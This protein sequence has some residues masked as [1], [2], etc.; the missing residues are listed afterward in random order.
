MHEPKASA[1]RNRDRYC[2]IRVRQIKT[3]GVHKE[4][5]AYHMTFSQSQVAGLA[6][7]SHSNLS[8]V[9][10]FER[11]PL[12]CESK[13]QLYVALLLVLGKQKVV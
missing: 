8:N 3:R 5:I 12:L 10:V 9:P 1:L 11:E 6:L 7:L 13:R 4:F 2:I